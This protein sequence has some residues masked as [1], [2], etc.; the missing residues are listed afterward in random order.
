MRSIAIFVAILSILGEISNANAK[1]EPPE[2]V[3]KLMKSD[4]EWVKE[5]DPQ[6]IH[7]AYGVEHDLRGKIIFMSF[8]SKNFDKQNYQRYIAWL[9]VD[10]KNCEV[11]KRLSEKGDGSTYEDIVTEKLSP[12]SHYLPK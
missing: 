5:T 12:L 11:L 7:F 1:C 3:G 10:S 6:N 8:D 4:S 9:T 2:V